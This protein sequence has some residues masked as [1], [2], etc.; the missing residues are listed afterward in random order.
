MVVVHPYGHTSPL[1]T[2]HKHTK[3]KE[4]IHFDQVSFQNNPRLFEDS[5]IF[6]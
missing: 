4:K 5:N 3:N 2:F 1:S 6:N